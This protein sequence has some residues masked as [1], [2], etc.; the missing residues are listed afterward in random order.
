MILGVPWPDIIIAIILL[1]S[2]YKGFSRGFVS[3]LGGAVAVAAALI[4]PWYYNGSFD[5]WIES[6]TK[7]GP[8]SAHVIGM[9]LCGFIT[10]AIVLAIAWTLNRIAK[11]P[12]LNIGNSLGGAA[13]GLAKGAVLIWLVLFIALYF[14]LSR[15]IRSDLHESRLAP[16]FVQADPKIDGV[17]ESVIPWF[18]RPALWPYFHRHHL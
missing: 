17:I 10:Y 9:F 4:T 7:L 11:L 13:I 18:A 14:P 15:D 6:G 3:E 5:E 1:I 2:S 12:L 16:F 8:G